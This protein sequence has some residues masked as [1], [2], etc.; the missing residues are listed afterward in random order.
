MRRRLAVLCLLAASALPLAARQRDRVLERAEQMLTGL[1]LQLRLVRNACHRPA[2]LLSRLQG[3]AYGTAA[4][5]P[6][7]NFARAGD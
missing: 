7:K 5:K 4:Q 1:P 3:P 2:S 6:A